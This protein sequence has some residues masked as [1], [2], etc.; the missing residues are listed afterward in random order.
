MRLTNGWPGDDEVEGPTNKHLEEL[1]MV[2]AF[3]IPQE[4]G[5]YQVSLCQALCEIPS[6]HDLI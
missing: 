3:L 1:D 2:P 6:L 4:D 5:V